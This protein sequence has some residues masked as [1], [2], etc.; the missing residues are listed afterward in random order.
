MLPSNLALRYQY[1]ASTSAS[2]TIRPNAVN[3]HWD[4]GKSLPPARCLFSA[5]G[6]T[7]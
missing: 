4:N 3:D 6:L 2:F 7:F 1:F 5:L